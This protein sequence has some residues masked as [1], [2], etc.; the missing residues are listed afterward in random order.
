MGCE[1]LFADQR[2]I[3]LGF[4]ARNINVLA[5][6]GNRRLRRRGLGLY[7][8]ALLVGPAND[9]EAFAGEGRSCTTHDKGNGQNAS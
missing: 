2:Y 7:D 1:T 9:P 5:H 6:L 8:H 3:G 4:L